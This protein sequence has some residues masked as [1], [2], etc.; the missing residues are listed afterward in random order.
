M[1]LI[2]VASVL[3]DAFAVLLAESDLASVHLQVAVALLLLLLLL[4]IAVATPAAEAEVVL[5]TA[6]DLA[7]VHLQTAVAA[8]VLVQHVLAFH[9]LIAF[10]AIVSHVIVQGV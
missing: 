1:P 10:V 4:R 6:S 3:V 5:L 7:S 9:C 2:A 8:V